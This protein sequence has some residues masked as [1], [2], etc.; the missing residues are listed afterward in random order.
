M[1]TLWL[2]TL[3]PCACH[4]YNRDFDTVL[5]QRA[6]I[7]LCLSVCACMWRKCSVNY[8]NLNGVI[9]FSL[10][11]TYLYETWVCVCA[12]CASVI[13]QYFFL[14][15]YDMHA[16]GNHLNRSI[17]LDVSRTVWTMRTSRERGWQY[18]CLPTHIN[19]RAYIR[20]NTFRKRSV[21]FTTNETRNGVQIEMWIFCTHLQAMRRRIRTSPCILY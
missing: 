3:E 5:L 10:P 8:T 2:F 14:F 15:R 7:C 4:V 17:I 18:V 16:C 11:L 6:C 20:I 19:S 12:V 1:D 9:M 13:S 21:V